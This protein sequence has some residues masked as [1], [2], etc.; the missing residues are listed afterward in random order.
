MTPIFAGTTAEMCTYLNCS[1]T[2][3]WRMMK[4][5]PECFKKLGKT[6]FLITL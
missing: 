6:I 1:R 3:L 5:R 2:T 4:Q